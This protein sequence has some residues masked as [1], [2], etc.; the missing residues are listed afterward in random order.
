M[1]SLVRLAWRLGIVALA[2]YAGMVALAALVQPEQREMALTVP[3]KPPA[4]HAKP[5]ERPRGGREAG[6]ESSQRRRLVTTLESLPFTS[7]N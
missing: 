7:N 1:P 3:L 4:Q 6:L 2:T 5:T